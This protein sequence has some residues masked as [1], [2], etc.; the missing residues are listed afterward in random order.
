M[1]VSK[2]I[3]V[4][5]SPKCTKST[6]DHFLDNT[7]NRTYPMESFALVHKSSIATVL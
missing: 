3:E 6:K 4:F 1:F 2:I 7:N 5:K